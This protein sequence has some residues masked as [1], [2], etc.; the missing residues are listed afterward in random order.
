MCL[1][2][3]QAV[4]QHDTGIRS[5]GAFPA[6]PRIG[7]AGAVS[8][9]GYIGQRV[10]H[11]RNLVGAVDPVGAALG[12]AFAACFAGHS[13]GVDLIGNQAGSV[14]GVEHCIIPVKMGFS[15]LG[16]VAADGEGNALMHIFAQPKCTSRPALTGAHRSGSKNP[17]SE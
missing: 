2:A 12:I 9:R 13:A 15:R 7:N 10:D 4:A 11:R 3:R 5:D 17:A 8:R 6:L 1:V 14:G 16:F